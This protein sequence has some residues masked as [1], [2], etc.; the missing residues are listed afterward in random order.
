MYSLEVGNRPSA[1]ILEE[2]EEE[3]STYLKY[4][5]GCCEDWM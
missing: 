2:K 5:C 1:Y 3:V 4:I